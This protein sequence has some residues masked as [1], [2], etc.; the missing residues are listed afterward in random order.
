MHEIIVSLTQKILH[1]EEGDLLLQCEM[2]RDLEHLVDLSQKRETA[3]A[4]VSVVIDLIKSNM[5]TGGIPSFVEALTASIDALVKELG[6][7]ENQEKEVEKEP[8]ESTDTANQHVNTEYLVTFIADAEERFSRAQQLLLTLENEN[9]ITELVQE[10]FRIFHTIKGECGFLKIATLGELAHNVENLL[11]LL[12]NKKIDVDTALVDILLEGV[13]HSKIILEE[14]KSGEVVLFNKTN[15]DE[16]I[17]NINKL[18]SSVH[19]SIGEILVNKGAIAES[20]RQRVLQLQKEGAYTEKFGEI[21]V[22]QDLVSKTDLDKILDAQKTVVEV[23]ETRSKKIEESDSFIRVRSS[24]V[25]YIVNMVGELLINMGQ[26]NDNSPAFRQMRKIT[27]ELQGAAMQLRTDTVQHLFGNIKRAV[28]DLS[29]KLDKPVRIETFGEDLEIDRNLLEK[30]EEPLVH[31]VRNC[32]DHGIEAATVRL[33]KKKPETGCVL[34]SAERKGNHIEICVEDDGAGLDREKIIN[35]AIEKGLVSKTGAA[36]L[37]D[38]EAYAFIFGNGFSTAEKVGYVSGRGV[39]MDIVRTTITALRGT[40]SIR[41]QK[42]HGTCF[43]LIFPLSTAIIDGV[44]VRVL[45]QYFIIPI[46]SVI[47]SLS[48]RT[49]KFTMVHEGIQVI[50]YREEIVPVIALQV[51]FDIEIAEESRGMG[52]IIED[53]T[54]KKYCIKVDEVISKNEIV[55]KNLGNYLKDVKGVS[56]CAVLQGG[57]IGLVLDVDQIV[58]ISQKQ[59]VA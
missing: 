45:D 5:K 31:L 27:R 18:V 22:N 33:E 25:Q 28:R 46:A 38:D 56:A 39:G 13:D 43:K 12:R 35:K 36:T 40:I 41:T 10:L 16:Y 57:R 4:A 11:D 2:I 51:L 44:V 32:L 17:R 53:A 6:S 49:Q 19:P 55:I 3:R 47:E 8:E 1:F 59:S 54:R 34:L 52:V 23:P 9:D 50:E 26:I 14:L 30:L 42:D 29:K 48:L 15:L 58:S 24:K 37:S 7:Q 20:D 21:A